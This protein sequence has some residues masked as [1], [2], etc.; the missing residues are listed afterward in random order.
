MTT[1][2]KVTDDDLDPM[3]NETVLKDW[4]FDH[5]RCFRCGIHNSMIDGLLSKF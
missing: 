3:D 4:G 1:K 2:G 5:N